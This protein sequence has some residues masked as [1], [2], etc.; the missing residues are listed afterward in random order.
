M[1]EYECE[2]AQKEGKIE[3]SVLRLHNVYGPPCEL[4]QE[5]SQVIPSLCRKAIL[6]PN[7]KFIVWGSGTQRRTFIY[8]RDVVDALMATLDSGMGKG[9]IQIGT[10]ESHSI[11]NVAE[12]I[13]G[14]SNKEIEIIFDLAKP[15]G[16][17][18]RVAD[19]TKAEKIL[20]WQ[21]KV[22]L[23]EGLEETYLWAKQKLES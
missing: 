3:V 17:K 16:D 20:G 15:E 6:Y 12:K 19:S 1:G 21:P 4:S 5:K 22:S 8:V 11:A 14:L 18:D 10:T 23:E 7:E 13:T 9:V 2:L